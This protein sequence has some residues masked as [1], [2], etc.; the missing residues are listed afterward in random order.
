MRQ[1]VDDYFGALWVSFPALEQYLTAGNGDLQMNG[2]YLSRVFDFD[3]D[4]GGPGACK[5]E[6][7]ACELRIISTLYKQ[8]F[9]LIIKSNEPRCRCRES[10]YRV[11]IG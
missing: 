11:P 9:T 10:V 4:D 3:C 7:L 2:A 6:I 5:R 1:R 8:F